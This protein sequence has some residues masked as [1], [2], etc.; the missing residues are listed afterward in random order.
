MA[1]FLIIDANSLIHR[2]YHALP[3]LTSLQ[4]KPV[5]ALYGLV[6]IFLKILKEEKPDYLAV[7]FDRPEPTFRKEVFI[8]YKAQRPP[9][10]SDLVEQI[11]E[12]HRF[13]Q[14]FQIPILEKPGYEADD[15][16]ATLVEKFK[17]IQDLKFIIFTGD[18]DTLQLVDDDQVVVKTF[19]K[20]ISEMI[21]YNEKAVIDRFGLKP[22][23]IPEYKSLVGDPSDNIPG[24]KGFGPKT[25]AQILNQYGSLD[26]LFQFLEKNPKNQLAQK[27]LPLKEEIIFYKNLTT[28]E[29]KVP[30]E[31]FTLENFLYREPPKNSLINYF[32]ELGF[33]SIINRFLKNQTTLPLEE[34]YFEEKKS[35]SEEEIEKLKIA[36]WLLDP[37][38][39]DLSL[40]ALAKRFLRKSD[41]HFQELSSF[42]YKKIDEYGLRD[43]FEKIELPLIP[44]LKK[45]EKNGIKVNPEKLKELEKE[46]DKE[47]EDLSQKIYKLVGQVFNLNSP[48]QLSEILFEK[49]K[50]KPPKI[51]TLEKRMFSTSE[52]ALFEI[53]E[54]HPV[55]DLILNYRESFKIKSTYLDPLQRLIQADG[56]IHA[57]F[58]QTGTA[59]GR[60]TSEKPNLQNIPQ[61][62]RWAKVLR[63]AFE[64]EKS[65][66][67]LSLDYSQIE[68][69]ILADITGEEKLKEAFEKDLDIHQ[70]TASQVFNL[71]LE[72]VTPDLRRIGKTLNFSIIYGIGPEALA[73]QIKTSKLEAKE[74]IEK[75]FENFP[76]IKIW[77][78]KI[79]T[80]ARTLGFVKNKNGRLR[81]FFQFLSSDPRFQKEAERA[82]INMPIQSLGADILKL[83][84]I[85]TDKL[86]QDQKW[87][88]QVKLVLSIHDELIFEVK[89]D[90]LENVINPL[91]TT[92]EKVYQLSV[93][94]KVEVK[95]GETW[96]N[97]KSFSK[98]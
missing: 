86:I 52:T 22:E 94:L 73:R 5:G 63:E 31:T 69:R 15:L 21:V 40:P 84:M 35:F 92:M 78:E 46:V 1:K 44:I 41:F 12:A 37:D 77:Q 18:L 76:K 81:W 7:C 60:L 17:N 72:E 61:I 71:P 53:K 38:Q 59:T 4:G 79:K 83:A 30:L 62:S 26:Q 82:A 66:V 45:M 6:N 85:E 33:Q 32:K 28:L 14:I 67:L 43:I 50:I 89:N 75:Y 55:I 64:A 95:F 24:I 2:T 11:I 3:P 8:N 9:T 96:G 13:F 51:K 29:K 70:L 88:D 20:G 90:I 25:T 56:R 93:P 58:F 65:W 10:P 74:F 47:L 57:R 54:E 68:L 39:K 34:K 98:N 91:K 42:I 19:K 97:L 80:E 49:L 16:I 23:K 87:Q 48:K 27:I 36:G